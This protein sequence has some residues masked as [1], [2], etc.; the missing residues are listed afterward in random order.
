MINAW[1]IVEDHYSETNLARRESLFSVG[2]GYFGLRGF[3]TERKPSHHPG[4]FINGFYELSPIEYGEH[5]YGFARWNQSMLDLPDSRYVEITIGDERFRMSEGKV[6]EFHREL[7]FRTGILSRT[8]TWE[9]P[10]GI[11]ARISWQ[12]L[13]SFVHMHLGAVR[14]IVETT[15]S[16]TVT[17]RSCIALP[18]ARPRDAADPRVG[19]EPGRT[20]LEHL[21]S[22]D[23]FQDGLCGLQSAYKTSV[24]NL[25][26]TCGMVNRCPEAE[27]SLQKDSSTGLQALDYSVEDGYVVFQKC[28]Y[29]HSSDKPWD[30][31]PLESVM[32][33]RYLAAS[34]SWE[35]L[36]TEQAEHLS[37][38][39]DDCDMEIM[40][41]DALQQA[42]RFNLFQLYQS[43]GKD[44][45]CSLAAKGLTG[46][47]YEGHYFWDTEIYAM[48]FFTFTRPE[49]ARSLI[50]YRISILDQARARAK[51][52][53]QK[54]ALFPWRTIN[55]LE[56][57]AYFPAGTAQYHINA[58]IAYSIIQYIDVTSD[59]TI[60]GDGAAE[61]LCETARLWADMGFFNPRKNNSFCIHEV[62]GPDEY[63][64]LVNNNFYTNVMVQHHLLGTVRLMRMMQKE[65]PVSWRNL[66]SKIYLE[67]VE[68]DVWEKAGLKMYVPYDEVLGIH[69]QD[70]SFLDR[71]PWDFLG[72]DAG[73]YPLLLYYHPLVIYRY[74]V[75]KQADSIL[76]LFL[77]HAK[78]PWY[79]RK[80]DFDYYE[81]L[82][83]G[84]SSL[85]ACIQ[86]IAAYDC[87]YAPLGMQYC[88]D[89]SLMDIE[90]LHKNTKDGLHTAAMAG[91]WMSMVYGLAGFRMVEGIPVFRPQLPKEW[92]LLRFKLKLSG[93]VLDIAI[94]PDETV[95]TRTGPPLVIRHLS[96]QLEVVSIARIRT[97]PTLRGVV[98]DL[99]GVISS[100]DEFHYQAWN[101]IAQKEGLRFSRE[102]NARLRGVSRYDSL[103]IILDHN[104]KK[105][106]TEK[107]SALMEEKNSLYRQSLKMLSHD[108]ILDGIEPLLQTLRQ[109]GIKL[110]LASASKNAPYIID[111]LGLEDSFDYIVPAEKLLFGKPDGEIFA[112]AADGL[113]LFPEECVGVEDAAAGITS[114]LHAHMMAVGV[115]TA[116]K[117]A[118]CNLHVMD[119]SQLTYEKISGLFS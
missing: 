19:S 59:T 79:Q 22:C 82:T 66:V 92:E 18:I 103:S 43:T 35:T 47:G 12:T 52:L 24:S 51:E 30:Q 114:I 61:L 75:L 34:M 119:T 57:S 4:V 63:S 33:S 73:K 5:A 37:Q 27:V 99:D 111:R 100:T 21:S 7:N 23:F 45:F 65:D 20:A 94:R 54:G 41:D 71:E 78:F 1:N 17:L 84:D 15:P 46:A 98:F 81:P 40:G 49:T 76:A 70:D 11:Q 29:Y 108:D 31:I 44:G 91:S 9:S 105:L 67:D 36:A 32:E 72:R 102:L 68:L 56:A 113:G 95:Y 42:I 117:D 26:L 80:R 14:V 86:G 101:T 96:Q 48:P 116:V 10:G 16:V 8:V 88:R 109:K 6:L 77:L 25:Y 74:Q 53:S 69:P 55:G 38:F 13:V 110:A 85:S 89:T 97:K 28:F 39:W 60:L 64:A 112:K 62:T 118:P 2:N 106:D 90:D 93:G 50:Q 87:G 3:F 58:D 104:G 107:M 83:T 115:G